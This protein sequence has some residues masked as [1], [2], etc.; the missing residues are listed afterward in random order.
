MVSPAYLRL[1]MFLL[2]ILIP[3]CASSTPAFLMIY[4]AYKLN[5]QGDNFQPWRTPFPIWNQSFGPCPVLTIASWPAYRFHRRQVVCT[6]NMFTCMCMLPHSVTYINMF[7]VYSLKW[8]C[9]QIIHTQTRSCTFTPSWSHIHSLIQMS[10]HR[11][12]LTWTRSCCC[13]CC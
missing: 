5:K 11:H 7:T 4:S 13:C 1:L 10:S 2:A 3:A 8:T 12:C 9:W 6:K